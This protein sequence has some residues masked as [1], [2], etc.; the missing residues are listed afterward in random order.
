M[1]LADAAVG[2]LMKVIGRNA[3]PQGGGATIAGLGIHV[4]EE[5]I[6]LRTAP[7]S[8]PILVEVPASGVR[9]AMG[10][11]MAE[12]VVVEPADAAA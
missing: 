12:A 6:I 4:G 1:T 3:P 5:V 11:G 8:G 9:V 7:F 10:R 2:K